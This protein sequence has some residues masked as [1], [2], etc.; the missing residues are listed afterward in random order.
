M[1]FLPGDLLLEITSWFHSRND[2]LHLAQTV[3]LL[4]LAL[5]F[6]RKYSRHSQSS[7]IYANVTPVLYANVT[8]GTTR[9]CIQ[10]LQMLYN[11]PEIARHT[12]RLSVRPDHDL[13][14]VPPIIQKAA[15][16]LDALNTFEWDADEMPDE[17]LWF[18]LRM[19]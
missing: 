2:I 18:V 8:L 9:Q 3:G 4:V 1:T 13:S 7:R 6:D 14:L 12:K 15:V 11:C 10:T 16:R 17:D 19:L 5:L